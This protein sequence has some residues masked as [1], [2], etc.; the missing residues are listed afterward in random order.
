[1]ISLTSL[2]RADATSSG[3]LCPGATYFQCR[4]QIAFGMTADTPTISAAIPS[5]R[6][7]S[8]VAADA[9]TIDDASP[10]PCAERGLFSGM[11]VDALTIASADPTAV[12]TPTIGAA[13]PP[14]RAE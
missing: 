8:D 3:L 14:T 1:M 5:P 13:K 7:E 6:T 9:P 12:D 2:S 11:S 4:A 10:A